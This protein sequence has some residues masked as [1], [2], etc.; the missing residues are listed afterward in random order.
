[1]IVGALGTN[2]DVISKVLST[3][4]FNGSW[5]GAIEYMKANGDIVSG[6]LGDIKTFLK[7][8]KHEQVVATIKSCSPNALGDL[9]VTVKDLSGTLA[10]S[11]HYKVI[12]EGGGIEMLMEEEEMA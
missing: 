8:E 4:Y 2:D 6:C 5:V 12:N 1:M 11:I 10:A 7:N 9:K 3:H